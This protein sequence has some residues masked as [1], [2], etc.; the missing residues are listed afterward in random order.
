MLG[1]RAVSEMT[2][3]TLKE[4]EGGVTPSLVLDDYES[5]KGIQFGH[6]IRSAF[7]MQEIVNLRLDTVDPSSRGFQA[8]VHANK[9]NLLFSVEWNYQNGNRR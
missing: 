5:L 2:C 6:S 1:T 7:R 3:S 4:D 8:L 9:E